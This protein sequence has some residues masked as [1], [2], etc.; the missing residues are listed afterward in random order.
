M[1]W[2]NH[3]GPQGHTYDMQQPLKASGTRIGYKTTIKGLKDTLM[4]WNNHQGPSVH[5]Y[6][7]EHPSKGSGTG[8]GYRTTIKG[9]EDTNM[10]TED[11]A[12]PPNSF[13]F[14]CSILFV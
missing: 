12:A 14:A 9:L 11:T 1:I 3:Q 7:M 13:S 10:M 4:I 8:I 6:D 2:N 5:T